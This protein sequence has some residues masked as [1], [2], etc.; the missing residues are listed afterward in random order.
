MVPVATNAPARWPLL[1]P[2]AVLGLE[3]NPGTSHVITFHT[4]HTVQNTVHI[5]TE[6]CRNHHPL[7]SS[8]FSLDCPS[9]QPPLLLGGGS[10]HGHSWD[11][12]GGEELRQFSWGWWCVFMWFG[13]ALACGGYTSRPVWEWLPGTV[14]APGADSPGTGT[15]VQP[16][17][18]VLVW[19]CPRT[20]GT[21]WVEEEKQGWKHGARN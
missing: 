13:V 12:A 3:L 9:V 4:A 11:L 1:L 18:C 21:E 6:S 8:P 7:R 5:C 17:G 10:D 14:P 2:Q 19:A 20:P 15:C 16:P